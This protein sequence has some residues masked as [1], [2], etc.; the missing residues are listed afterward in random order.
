MLFRSTKYT[1]RGYEGDLVDS[2]DSVH[3][4]GVLLTG[5]I[6]FGKAVRTDG[7]GQGIQVGATNV[8]NVCSVFGITLREYNHEAGTRPS[9]GTDFLYR[10][11]ES[12]SIL[13][14]GYIYL[15]LTGATAISREEELHVDAVTGLFTKVAAAGNVAVCRNVYATQPATTNQVFKARIDISRT[16]AA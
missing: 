13:R 16:Q 1:A 8:S 10:A 15:K 3:Q 7:E 11:N 4:T 2:G 14:Q 12:V 5:T 6:G 9:D